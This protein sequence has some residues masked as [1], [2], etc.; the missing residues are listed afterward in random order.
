MGT[1]I[2][3]TVVTG[4]FAHALSLIAKMV[5]LEI[6]LSRPYT[7]KFRKNMGADTHS[8]LSPQYP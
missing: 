2:K 4:I 7:R 1:A 5:R 3:L 8:E 6:K